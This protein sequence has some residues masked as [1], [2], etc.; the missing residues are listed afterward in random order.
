MSDETV[1]FCNI[2][3]QEEE[4][5]SS[6][7]EEYLLKKAELNS[8]YN[9]SL[10][11][12]VVTCIFFIIFIII[13]IILLVKKSKKSKKSKKNKNSKNSKFDVKK[14]IA[15]VLFFIAFLCS[16]TSITMSYF[17]NKNKNDRDGLVEPV[18]DDKYR[19]CYSKIQNKLIEDLISAPVDSNG[20][21]ISIGS[22]GILSGPVGSFVFSEDTSKMLDIS[23][24]VLTRN[25]SR[26]KEL[27]YS[28]TSNSQ[29]SATASTTTGPTVN[30]N[31]QSGTA[32]AA[33]SG[34]TSSQV[35]L[36]LL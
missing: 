15:I 16:T 34:G 22:E 24:N 3:I 2:I 36:T 9:N 20:L 21:R 32:T 18:I 14:I 1:K 12:V 11:G 31:T 27:Q 29:S 8:K 33:A 4:Y 30:G 19:P 25:Q 23:N 13:G 5:Y 26:D 28:A 6:I 10:T 17:T 35:D 7:E